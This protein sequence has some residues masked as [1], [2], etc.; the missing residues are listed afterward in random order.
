[1]LDRYIEPELV[2]RPKTGFEPPL[3][4]WLRTT[5]R[6]WAELLLDISRL[7]AEGFFEPEPVRAWWREHLEGRDRT[8]PVW[9]V[10]VFQSWLERRAGDT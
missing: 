4:A 2:D 10:L 3:G 8:Y 1:V 5:L 9:S 7:R 6:D